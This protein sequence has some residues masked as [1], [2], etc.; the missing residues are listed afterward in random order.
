MKIGCSAS[1][2]EISLVHAMGFD[3]VE[4]RGRD[5]AALSKAE[6]DALEAQI[7]RLA[8][9]CLSLNAYC[10][11]DIK[12]AG[13]GFDLQ[14]S[15]LYADALAERASRIGVKV[16]GIGSPLS[17]RLPDG[18]DRQLAWEQA[19]AFTRE[20]AEA[21]AK[22]GVRTGFEPLGY[23][24]CNF[25]NH[26]DEAVKLADTLKSCGVGLTLDFYNMERSQEDMMPLAVCAPHILHV[27][28]SDDLEGNPQKRAFLRQD[29]LEIHRERI[30]RLMATGYDGTVSLEVDIPINDAAA[31]NLAFLRK[32][33]A[34]FQ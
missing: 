18:F 11:P 34:E 1:I 32:T 3:F 6:M 14:R 29:K 23:C 21:F 4:L 5:V 16:I 33:V 20:T 27:H 25:V 15:R 7:S 26:V 2:P 19:V 30:H 12:I 28:V 9:P 13:P 31:E 22:Y 8:L 17:R 24:Y 10:P